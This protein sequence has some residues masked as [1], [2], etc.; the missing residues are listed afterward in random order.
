[1]IY[2]LTGKIIKKTLDS[3]VI[4]CGG[5]GYFV[6][7]PAT[8]GEALPPA[9]QEGTVYTIMNVTENDV[10]LYGFAA[11]EQRDCFKM[12]TGV[13]GVGPKAALSILSI[14]TPE[15]IALAASSGDHKAFTKAAGVGPK[16]AQ[17]ITLELKDKVGKGLAAGTG[18]SGNVAA[19]APSS[20]PA[21]AVAALVSLGY[22]PSDAAAAVAR[23]DETL[24]V[25][26]II[27]IAL[28]SLSRVSIGLLLA[29]A[30]A[31]ALWVFL[32]RTRAGFAQQVGGLAPAAARYAGFSSRRALW[33]ALLISGGAA[34]LAGAL[35]VAGPIGQLTPYVPAGYGFAAIIVAFVGRLHPVGMI[36]SAI[37]MS[38]FYIGGELAQSRL[39]LPKSLTGVF[40]GLLLFTL[41]A[42]DTLIAYR[43]R[44]VASKGGK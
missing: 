22:A 21:Q 29:L 14:M 37:L 40:Q 44:W 24:S 15:K 42:C 5:V 20:A 3:V 27:T 7:I 39:G 26:E 17:R 32:F 30:G 10:S 9:G 41:L 38:M 13:T 28:R 34:G 16:L 4:S 35:E 31:A 1:M 25:Q 6:Q 2:C 11:E 43:I 18:F 8:T 33:T 36:L 23:V 12:L 19:P